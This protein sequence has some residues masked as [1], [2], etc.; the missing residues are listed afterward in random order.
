MT[1]GNGVEVPTPGLPSTATGGVD[2][3]AGSNDLAMPQIGEKEAHGLSTYG[4]ASDT[5]NSSMV[6]MAG[7]GSE[8]T[9]MNTVN[10]DMSGNSSMQNMTGAQLGAQT[11]QMNTDSA[12]RWQQSRGGNND[13][14]WNDAA[15]YE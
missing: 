11:Q 3:T 4:A 5:G 1:A 6:N 13:R 10:A 14:N 9:T 12:G 2:P 15:K 8:E 7:P